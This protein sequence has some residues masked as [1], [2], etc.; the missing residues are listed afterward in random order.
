VL[1]VD[2]PSR[3]DLEQL[4]GRRD[5]ASVSIYLPTTPVTPDTQADRIQ[6]GNL[7]RDALEQLRAAGRDDKA[8]QAVAGHLDDLADDDGFWAVQAR[9]LAIFATP[10]HL[11]TFRLAN[12]LNPMI[13]VADRF[14]VKPLIR[15]VTVNQEAFVL[16]LSQNAVRVVEVS[17]D[18]P[19]SPIR[20]A[21]MPKDMVDAVGRSSLTSRSPRGRL[22]GDE[23]RK[24]RM[25]QF[26]RAVDGALRDLLSGRETPLI[27]AAA[28]PLD[29]IFRSTC[30]YPH[31]AGETIAGNPDMTS[32]HDLAVAARGILDTLH[33]DKVR[34]FADRFDARAGQGWTTTDI[35]QAAKAATYGA[36][37]TIAVDIDAYAPG[38]IDDAD[39][40]I[41]LADEAGADSYGITDEIVGRVLLTGGHV[42]AVRRY[43]VPGGGTLAAILRYAL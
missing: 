14:Y 40:S 5:P 23:G 41:T 30:S 18:E 33:A 12:R 7:A 34:T 31:L 11:L 4:I 1:Y 8:V 43:D 13:E 20:V 6:L 39:G 22:Q 42:L 26:A 24:V 15:A 19:A 38:V 3:S 16:A 17:A 32:D 25:A 28:P 10:G 2:L 29:S 9:S 27:L 21:D 35:A 37:D 36:V